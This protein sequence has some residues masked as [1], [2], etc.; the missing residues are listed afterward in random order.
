ML[1]NSIKRKIEIEQE[2]RLNPQP[3]NIEIEEEI[4]LNSQAKKV[5]IEPE[6]IIDPH[7]RE[8]QIESSEK[9]LLSATKD[10]EV[11]Y[12]N[13]DSLLESIYSNKIEVEF[14]DKQKGMSKST[15]QSLIENG[16]VKA[17][18]STNELSVFDEGITLDKTAKENKV[19]D[20]TIHV[21]NV[22]K[23]AELDD[24][25]LHLDKI[26]K[27]ITIDKDIL[28]DKATKNA[29]IEVETK[30]DR[31]K[32]QK[33]QKE[34]E[35]RLNLHKRFWFLESLGEMDYKILPNVD[36][37]YPPNIE[38]FKT[39]IPNQKYVYKYVDKFKELGNYRV[40]LHKE[41]LTILGQQDRKSVV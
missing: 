12:D 20:D 4:R 26:R 38:V 19:N 18:K 7:E 30:L 9:Q 22:A 15:K 23:K 34:I 21:D 37:K 39:N 3:L 5:D 32:E 1:M 6:I 27:K 31:S 28:L 10:L 29:F 41:D 14:G 17:G 16:V 40:R 36:Y 25:S 24:D 33:I 11:K 35:E 13:K 8:I 2:T